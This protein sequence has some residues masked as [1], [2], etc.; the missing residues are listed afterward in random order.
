VT[1]PGRGWA[2]ESSVFEARHAAARKRDRKVNGLDASSR[3]AV[4]VAAG[5]L[6]GDGRAECNLGQGEG[7]NHLVRAYDGDHVNYDPTTLQTPTQLLSL[8]VQFGVGGGW[9]VAEVDV[10]KRLACRDVPSRPRSQG[11]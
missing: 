2:P 4:Y 5:D 1:A 9:R 3:E 8:G 11:R 6:H 7:G 10:D